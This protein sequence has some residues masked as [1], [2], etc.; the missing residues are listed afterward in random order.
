MKNE[1]RAIIRWIPA[2]RGGRRQP[3][4]D[5]AGY[6]A[7]AR[8][9]SDPAGSRG[10]WSL[11]ILAAAPLRGPEVIDAKISFLFA[12]APADLLRE[13]ERFELLE[14]KKVVAKGVILP[15][16]LNPPRQLDEFELALLG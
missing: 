5:A 13:G 1:H 9:E 10:D 7:P 12:D 4:L 15:S 11:R 16:A 14:G 6:A 8:F 2:S 3:P